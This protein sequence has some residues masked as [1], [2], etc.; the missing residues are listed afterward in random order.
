MGRRAHRKGMHKMERRDYEMF[1]GCRLDSQLNVEP[2]GCRGACITDPLVTG[3]D[4]GYLDLC[5]VQYKV[6][7]RWEVFCIGWQ[8]CTCMGTAV[9]LV[10]PSQ[11][12]AGTSAAQR[13]CVPALLAPD[14][15]PLP[16][17]NYTGEDIT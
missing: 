2:T 6:L 11:S 5:G 10:F 8:G 3:A 14:S 12:S 13:H 16:I 4:Q 7:R 9:L 1:G 15:Q 17:F